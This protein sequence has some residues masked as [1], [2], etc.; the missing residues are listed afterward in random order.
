MTVG[1]L[2]HFMFE[3]IYVVCFSC[4]LLFFSVTF[5]AAMLATSLPERS[6]ILVGLTWIKKELDKKKK[7]IMKCDLQ[8]P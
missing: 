1:T 6:L 3:W 2:R 4:C 5:E 7:T 8:L